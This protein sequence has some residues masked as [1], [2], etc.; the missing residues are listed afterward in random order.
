M[1]NFRG[2]GKVT[3]MK[4]YLKSLA[5]LAILIGTIQPVFGL[6]MMDPR[7][8]ETTTSKEFWNVLGRT[9]PGSSVTVSG[10]PAVV[11]GT[12]L[13]ILDRLPLSMGDNQLEVSATTP[14]G[15]HE[16]TTIVIRRVVPGAE[17]PRPEARRRRDG[18]QR[19][20][21][22]PR[23]P[24]KEQP[25]GPIVSSS[26][27]PNLDTILQQGDVLNVSF[28][29]PSGGKAAFSTVSGDRFPMREEIN[30]VSG[31]PTGKYAAAVALTRAETSGPLTLQLDIPTS[32]IRARVKTKALVEVNDGRQVQIGV[33]KND[34]GQLLFGLH[35]VRL[36]G[37]FLAELSSGTILRLTG[38]VGGNYHV[39][40]S[41]S[42]DAWID[43]SDV[44]FTSAPATMP[45][46]AFTD[47]SVTGN[48][49]YDTIS[50]PLPERVPFAITPIS[51]PD[52]NASL[53]IDIYGAHNAAT[54]ISQR[55]TAK[56]VREVTTEQ[57]ET[58]HVRVH[59]ELN[60]RLLWGYRYEVTPGSLRVL[61]R[62][63]PKFS[64]NAER[65]FEGLT[66]AVEAG[67]GGAKNAGARGVSGSDEKDINLKTAKQLADV[68]TSGG[69]NVVLVRKDDT[70]LSMM[71]RVS[72]A[73]DADADLFISVHANSAGNERGYLAVSGTSTYYKYPF[74]HDLAEAVHTRL[75][76][77]LKINDF[78]N[79]GSFNYY[80]LRKITWMPSM[81][82]EQAF[83][84]NP[85]DEAWMLDPA[86]RQRLAQAVADGTA[87]FL[88]QAGELEHK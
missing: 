12:G 10:K 43:A 80:P 44:V 75:L 28:E 1:Y 6:K 65:P 20:G 5:C 24:G 4:H 25:A 35:E 63:A 84:S 49:S 2:L 29:G 56:V 51:G 3:P 8:T 31:K 9:E 64:Q 42:L 18:G 61:V 52:R 55:P 77:A 17:G 78:G 82:V 85:Q 19:P 81:L 37:P 46:V 69:A 34:F 79:V 45:H 14:D 40:L 11:V 21:R 60:N 47:I 41:P 86:F 74:S 15:K 76:D 73:M 71:E 58:D 38:K 50:I 13:F 88:K 27:I 83:M 36:G 30:S 62:H 72:G 39:K 23:Q 48:E 59:A 67:H 68:L 22:G 66:I 7:D 57:V 53:N 87:D 32:H 33:V 26:I 54:W 16:T 70:N